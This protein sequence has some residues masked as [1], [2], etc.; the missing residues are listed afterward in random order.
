MVCDKTKI[1]GTFK[2]GEQVVVVDLGMFCSIETVQKI[3]DVLRDEANN[4]GEYLNLTVK[5]SMEDI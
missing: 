4:L 5:I 1:V 3:C 2:D